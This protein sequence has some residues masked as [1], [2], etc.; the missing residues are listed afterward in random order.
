MAR[1]STEYY[2]ENKKT[3]RV[4]HKCTHCS[5][6][7]T[8]CKLQLMNH[9]YARHTP[10][11]RRPFQCEH[12]FRGFAQ[13]AHLYNHLLKTHDIDMS[14]KKKKIAT[15]AYLIQLTEEEAKSKK[16][17]AR[18]LFYR[19]HLCIKGRDIKNKKI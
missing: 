19:N 7:T 15:N 4:I 5:Y 18:S 8:G 13:K 12:C 14:T 17:R 2:R 16:T 10:E 6:E 9:I 11:N 1:N 3:R